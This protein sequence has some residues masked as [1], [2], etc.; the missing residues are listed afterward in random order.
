MDVGVGS[1][2]NPPEL[3]CFVLSLFPPARRS[4]SLKGGRKIKFLAGYFSNSVSTWQQHSW[5]YNLTSCCR[6]GLAHF[7]EHMLFLGTKSFPDEREFDFYLGAHA[8]HS[9]AY[10]SS[11][12]TNYMFKVVWLCSFS[13]ILFHDFVVTLPFS[14]F[15]LY[16]SLPLLFL[17]SLKGG[18]ELLRRR[19]ESVVWVLL[20]APPVCVRDRSGTQRC[21]L[22]FALTFFFSLLSSLSSRHPLN[23]SSCSQDHISFL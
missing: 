22:R 10:T 5:F 16:P 18:R 2:S 20:R 21:Q 1:F 19:F 7:L 12:N 17:S 6:P 13:W 8:G 3:Y 23:L 11:E 14:A 15:S 4:Y 9:N